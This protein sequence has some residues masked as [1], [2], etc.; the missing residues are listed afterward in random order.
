MKLV[1]KV[2]DNS[3]KDFS[4]TVVVDLPF[5]DYATIKDCCNNCTADEYDRS[6]NKLCDKV[7]A[8]IYET[9]DWYID[10]FSCD[11]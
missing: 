5:G 11:D 1:V 10:K 3:N 7:G 8:Q 4:K 2:G 6:W 9:D